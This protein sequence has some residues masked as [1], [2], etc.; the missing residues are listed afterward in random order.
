MQEHVSD[1]YVKR[2]QREGY[3]S[4]A[5]FK[6]ME[7]DDRDK[8]IQPG[9]T[10]VDL[11]ATPG[12]WSQVVVERLKGKGRVIAL[13]ILE[14]QPMTGVEFLQGDFRET[15]VLSRLEQTLDGR[16]V[17][18]VISDMAPNMSGVGLVDQARAM[19]LAELS[20]AFALEW[21]KPGGNFLVK[22]FIG[23]GFEELVRAMRPAFEKVATRKPKASRD[24]SAET[25]LLGMKRKAAD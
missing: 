17:D 12:S 21:L 24:R 25:Y 20:L 2:A 5:A 19:D 16:K 7:I 4:R 9:M 6:L 3:R 23:S 10:V 1:A 22:V 8:L 11:G 13:D 15:E 18:L 14:M